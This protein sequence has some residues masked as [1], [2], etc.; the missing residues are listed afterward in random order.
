MR[1]SERERERERERALLGIMESVLFIGT[2]FS[3]FYTDICTD[4]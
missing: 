4:I 3:N 2:E 1:E